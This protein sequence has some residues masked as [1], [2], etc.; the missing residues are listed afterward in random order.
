[1]EI[2]EGKKKGWLRDPQT[3]TS[4][5]LSPALL[6]ISVKRYRCS[7]ATV[8][9][10]PTSQRLLPG[11][12][13]PKLLGHQ[14]SGVRLQAMSGVYPKPPFGLNGSIMYEKGRYMLPESLSYAQ[15]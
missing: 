15:T 6:G 2:Q 12:Y 14:H 10:H 3:S 9:Q 1:M 7:A 13:P 5:K 8:P 4:T 11:W